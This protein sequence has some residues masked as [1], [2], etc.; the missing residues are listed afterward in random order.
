MTVLGWLVVGLVGAARGR[1]T[2]ER[3]RAKVGTGALLLDVRT[4]A[5]HRAGAIP[6]STNVPLQSRRA[7]LAELDPKRP[8]VVYC[9]SGLRSAS[10]AALLRRSGFAEVHDLGPASVW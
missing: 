5:E 10:A 1:I 3:A 9:A 8:V 2:G 4:E 6:G 7:R